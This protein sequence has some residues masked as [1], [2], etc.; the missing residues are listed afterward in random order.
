MIIEANS[1]KTT[2]DWKASLKILT[3]QLET[4][5]LTCQEAAIWSEMAGMV[6]VT[7]GATIKITGNYPSSL[8]PTLEK[9]RNNTP[10]TL[11]QIR[12]GI[13]ERLLA[14]FPR[15]ETALDQM[16]W[17]H[18][19]TLL[20]LPEYETQVLTAAARQLAIYPNDQNGT[21]IDTFQCLCLA[22]WYCNHHLEIAPYSLA[23]VPQAVALFDMP[24]V[25]N[26][27]ARV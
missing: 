10:E 25:K 5:D 23:R 6:A 7:E 22:L 15:Y 18:L 17:N 24:P 9:L 11:E 21:A 4:V 26:M 8:K 3:K 14:Q 20:E 27:E 16:D 2:R 1:K 13:L 12:E 19:P